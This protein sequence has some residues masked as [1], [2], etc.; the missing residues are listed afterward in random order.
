MLTGQRGAWSVTFTY[1][2]ANRV[3]NT[4]Q[5]GQ[6]IAYSYNIP[7][8]TR[9]VTYPGSRVI[10]EHTDARTRLDHIDDAASPPP[11]VQYTYDLA[12]RVTA[13]RTA[14]DRRR[15]QLQRE[16]LDRQ[17]SNIPMAPRRSPASATPTTT[18]ATS[19]SNKSC[20]TPPIRRLPV[21]QR[22]PADQLQSGHAGRLHGAGP[23]HP[24]RY[25]LDPGRQLEQQDHRLPSLQTRMHNCR[26]RADSDRCR[27]HSPTTPTAT[28][29]TDPAFDP[30]RHATTKKTA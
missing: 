26:Q 1:D 21:R 18:K 9:T 5:N 8:R 16:Q 15:L 3:T 19:S 28:C 7:G 24:D 12:N 29:R 14:T 27:R 6:T 17:I 13:A 4:V 30:I 20:R 23:Q 22:L 2:G 11:I 25:N 10:T